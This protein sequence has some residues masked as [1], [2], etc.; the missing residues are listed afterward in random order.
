MLLRTE[1]S[2]AMIGRSLLAATALAALTAWPASALEVVASIEPLHS[3]V[4]GVMGDAGTPKL[5]VRGDASP[6]TYALRPSD[7][8]ALE[9]AELVFWIGPGMEAF[10]DKPLASLAADAKVVEIAWQK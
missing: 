7:A 6:H 2:M 1:T 5:I 4:A 10:L 9:A 8:A 3:L